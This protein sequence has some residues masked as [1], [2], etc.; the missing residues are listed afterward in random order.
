M[1][2]VTTVTFTPEEAKLVFSGVGNL[3]LYTVQGS[4]AIGGSGMTPGDGLYMG[5]P[6]SR[7]SVNVTSPDDIYV[8]NDSGVSSNGELR[9][10]HN[11]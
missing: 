10:Y 5:G 2:S 7:T 4:L 8:L 1:A 3:I 11:R 6:G 9:I